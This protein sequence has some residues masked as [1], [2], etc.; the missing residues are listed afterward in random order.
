M[1]IDVGRTKNEIMMLLKK[2]GGLTTEELSGQIGITP[3]GIRQHL[4]ALERKN[5]ISH[6]MK[7]Q[8]IGR[9]TFIYRLTD[10]ADDIFPKDYSGFALNLL[11]DL[12]AMDGREKIDALFKRRKEKLLRER[13]QLLARYD[14]NGKVRALSNLFEEDGYFVELANGRQ[15]YILNLYN[16]LFLKI[17][18]RYRTACNYEIELVAELLGRQVTLEKTAS[19][20]DTFCSVRIPKR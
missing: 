2:T 16:C 3:M 8:G 1:R 19:A 18:N 4:L 12:E 17:S 14:F 15:N 13:G 11:S 6:E 9:P 10:T 20:G 7:K 5:L